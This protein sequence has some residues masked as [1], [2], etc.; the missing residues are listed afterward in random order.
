ASTTSRQ[1]CSVPKQVSTRYIASPKKLWR[2]ASSK[3]AKKPDDLFNP[4]NGVRP[5]GRMVND[6]LGTPG[7]SA[8]GCRFAGVGATRR[9]AT[10]C[11]KAAFGDGIG[12]GSTPRRGNAKAN[13]S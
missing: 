12:A 4:V 1:S 6:F 10:F 9:H 8:F 2:R 13:R 3:S 7:N 11:L 5:N